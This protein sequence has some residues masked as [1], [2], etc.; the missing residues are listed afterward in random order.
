MAM[1]LLTRQTIL[2]GK[3][4]IIFLFLHLH[5]LNFSISFSKLI[6]I[7]IKMKH[8]FNILNSSAVILLLVTIMMPYSAFTQ[9]CPGNK[10][11]ISF[12][13][14]TKTST[15]IEFDVSLKNTGTT[16]LK[17]AAFAGGLTY[18]VGTLP[19]GATGTLTVVDQPSASASAFPTISNIAP[20][21]NATLRHLRWTNTPI[22]GEATSVSMPQG[23]S[24]KFARL[25]FTSS[26]PWTISSTD[27]TWQ[28][29]TTGGYTVP[30][31]TVYCEGGTNSTALT[32]ANG[33]IDA[34]PS[35]A[36]ALPIE[37]TSFTG[38]TL[39]QSNLLQW[40]TASER[41]VQWHNIERSV[42]GIN[43][44]TLVGKIAGKG[45]SQSE[46]RYSLE[47]RAP[48][49]QSYYRLRSVDNDGQEQISQVIT[50]TRKDARFGILSAFPN[51]ATESIAV[52]FNTNE[53]GT[54]TARITD[55][56][57]R[58]VAQ[59]QMGAEKGINMLPIQLGQLSAGTYFVTLQNGS[60][61]TEPVRFVKQ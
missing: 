30:N 8:F 20:N 4:I 11:E 13:N 46:Q 57:G 16:T 29:T 5:L 34:V 15:T 45:D 50:L 41:N 25:K 59:Q 39:E 6:K 17:L 24:M 18:S 27:F 60:N 56:T 58:L 51:P 12:Q 10:I 53:E 23:T 36:I 26:L 19:S 40:T 32:I 44:W 48:L 31:A 2:F 35:L 3:P 22:Q 61:I 21:H 47:D 38:K 52:Q 37:L 55:V 42:D 9:A 54:V 1:V 43:G 14:I 49:A 28:G 7:F 33:L